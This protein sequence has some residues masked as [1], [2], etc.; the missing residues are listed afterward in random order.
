MTSVE[1]TAVFFNTILKLIIVALSVMAVDH[2]CI[3]RVVNEGVSVALH[4]IDGFISCL[5]FCG[6]GLFKVPFH[7]I[8]NVAN[9]F[10]IAL[11]K[12]KSQAILVPPSC[13]DVHQN[14]CCCATISFA[15]VEHAVLLI[16]RICI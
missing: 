6:G 2:F 11:S 12:D 8:F 4:C 15:G 5:F 1:I 14:T 13:L 16:C 3:F 9:G 10:V 7:Q